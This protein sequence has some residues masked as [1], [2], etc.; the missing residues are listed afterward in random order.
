VSGYIVSFGLYQGKGVSADTTENV[1]AV[2]AAANSVLDLLDLI[3][4]EKLDLPYDIFASNSLFSS[5]K[6]I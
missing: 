2:G 6:L 5:C 1:K 3:P 4:K